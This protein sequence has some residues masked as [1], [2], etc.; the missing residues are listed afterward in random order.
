MQ[1]GAAVAHAQGLS[2][3]PHE[4]LLDMSFG[5]LQGLT[6]DEANARYADVLKAWLE[7]PHQIHFPGGE[8]LDTVRQRVMT[9]LEDLVCRHRGE[10][11]ALVSHTVVIK[12]LLCAVLGLGNEHFWRI[13]QD[14]CAVNA[15]DAED[16]A[17]DGGGAIYTIQ[18]IND[19]SHMCDLSAHA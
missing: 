9:G 17:A 12:T 18:L 13:G 2:V 3:Q 1:T 19:T 10:S 6:M 14:T 4:G 7:T 11:V 16:G 5:K 15:F 8:D